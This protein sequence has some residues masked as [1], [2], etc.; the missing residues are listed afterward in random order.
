MSGRPG[1]M[2]D[3]AERKLETDPSEA[4]ATGLAEAMVIDPEEQLAT[5]AA[6]LYFVAGLTQIEI[7]RKL[8]V[9]R[10]RVN[11]LLAQA[12]RRDWCRSA[13]RDG[14]PTAWSSR[15]GSRTASSWKRP[16]LCPRRRARRWCRM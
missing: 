4:V 9:N 5:R 10:I 3:A 7:G 16:S 11:R 2:T 8:G 15:S 6:W 1:G 14:S 13:S 12:R